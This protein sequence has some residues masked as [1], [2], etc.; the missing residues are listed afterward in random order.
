MPRFRPE[1]H[2][3]AAWVP[4]QRARVCVVPVVI[5]ILLLA[6]PGGQAIA[7]DD[8]GK[9]KVKELPEHWRVWLE[10]EVYP[11]ISPDQKN[12]FLHMTT[13]AQRRAF[14]TRLWQLWGR[15]TGHGARFRIMYEERIKLVRE[16]FRQPTEERARVLLIQ[17]PPNF[18][19]ASQCSEIFHP[20]IIWG[21]GYIEGLGEDVVALF[22][23]PDGLGNFRLWT[24]FD[25]RER[26][27]TFTAWE[28]QLRR[29]QSAFRQGP[30]SRCANGDQ[31]VG[32]MARAARWSR[33]PK[34]L[35]AMHNLPR[36]ERAGAESSTHRFMEFSALFDEDAVEMDFDIAGAERGLQG[37]KVRMGFNITVPTS[38]LGTTQVGDVEVAQI[39][40]VGEIN[41]D[42]VMLDRFRYLFSVPSVGDEL[43]MLVERFLRSG[44]YTLRLKVED[45]HSPHEG[46]VEWPFSVD[47]GRGKAAQ[48]AEQERRKGLVQ[49]LEVGDEIDGEEPLRGSPG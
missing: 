8:P 46:I 27:Y 25:G 48:E 44:D 7:G 38:V 43:V 30:E 4:V 10:E 5:V 24:D 19:L 35:E 14:A 16:V 18:E 49:R 39:D 32:L 40:I 45:A 47:M 28:A 13:E 23:Q 21:W 22:Y 9:L 29:N 34:Y 12:A 42:E 33:D 3:P 37:G 31:I 17:G 36:V 11:L 6:G 2:T 20:I 15:Q 1:R 41:R 26:L